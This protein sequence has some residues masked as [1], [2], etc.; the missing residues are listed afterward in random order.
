M[1]AWNVVRRGGRAV[2]PALPGSAAGLARLLYRIGEKGY[3]NYK[4][5]G[6]FSGQRSMVQR[7]TDMAR[8]RKSSRSSK[9]RSARA[10]PAPV[11]VGKIGTVYSASTGSKIGVKMSKGKKKKPSTFR[12]GVS[13]T[14]INS[15][16][17]IGVPGNP[18]VYIGH[19]S[20]PLAKVRQMAW[21]AMLKAFLSSIQFDVVDWDYEIP[22]TAS[23]AID[24]VY[25][26][27]SELPIAIDALTIGAG[28]YTLSSLAAY[29][30][31]VTRPWNQNPDVPDCR[32]LK[33]TYIPG[34]TQRVLSSSFFRL[35]NAKVTFE[36]ESKIQ[37]QNATGSWDADGQ[38]SA[39]NIANVP[40]EGLA[41]AGSGTGALANTYAYNPAA[42]SAVAVNFISD[43]QTGLILVT[44]SHAPSEVF[45][46][47]PPSK[48][49]FLNVSKTRKV[50]M[51]PGVIEN[52]SLR[53]S[54]TKVF[55][56]IFND[57]HLMQQASLPRF[58]NRPK[59]GNYEFF[60]VHPVIQASATLTPAMAYE[61]KWKSSAKFHGSTRPVTHTEVDL[62][63]TQF[64]T[65]QPA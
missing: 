21:L 55:S 7:A 65:I 63:V 51:E 28:T 5:S 18:V 13:A 57:L 46:V 4:K 25:Q 56:K 45:N 62:T 14:A 52:N 41:Y 36:A 24:M 2:G 38:N 54:F 48:K 43:Q 47:D 50:V 10:K 31:D 29:Y 44:G 6:S 34:T 19:A 30:M 23:C 12:N 17:V 3:S 15:G 33:L 64:S 9:L 35:D 11:K 59:I 61:I 27:N 32:F 60:G 1:P 8:S 22:F 16:T 42:P 49:S 58:V 20:A 37:L 39:D 26:L 40:L 53:Y